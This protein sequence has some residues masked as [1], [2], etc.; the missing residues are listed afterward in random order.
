MESPQEQFQST[1]TS[2]PPTLQATIQ[3]ETTVG[4]GRRIGF[5]VGYIFTFVVAYA[6]IANVLVIG[7]LI[8]YFILWENLP[9][10][11]FGIEKVAAFI[12]AIFLAW[13][14]GKYFHWQV[15]K[16]VV[17]PHPAHGRI[18]RVS[19]FALYS[20]FILAFVLVITPSVLGLFFR[21]IATTDDTDL[22]LPTL[23]IQ[24][25]QNALTDLTTAGE[26]LDKTYDTEKLR[27]ILSGK[28]WDAAF[29]AQAIASNTPAL[30]LYAT[31]AS[32]SVFQDPVPAKPDTLS[33]ASILPT[34]SPWRTLDRF[35]GVS[36]LYLAHQGKS[37]EA[38]QTVLVGV[39]VGHK[40]ETSQGHLIEWLVGY[41]IKIQALET[42]QRIIASSSITTKDLKSVA[43][44]LRTYTD[45]RS[46][47]IKAMKVEYYSMKNQIDMIAHG[48]TQD[49]GGTG[50]LIMLSSSIDRTSFY[51]HPNQSISYLA[52][53]RKDDIKNIQSGCN[54]IKQKEITKLA[55]TNLA[56]LYFTPNAIGIILHD[57]VAVSLGNNLNTK[58]CQ[59]N[60]LLN[61]T[62]LLAAIKAY[63][64]DNKG[65]LPTSLD[66]LVPTYLSDMPL[67]PFTGQA[68]K[69]D[70]AKQII[71][72]IGQNK[73]DVGGSVGDSWNQMENPTFSVAF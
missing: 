63:K 71:Y 36:A 66:E 51:F 45:D 7:T 52:D 48:D 20:M 46:G 1:P 16:R 28:T 34:L 3:T 64:Q 23:S 35:N 22:Q 24:D 10:G 53:E 49:A 59:E 43:E 44:S 60:T 11:A 26:A 67:D 50:N 27:A 30:S 62:R 42:I 21:D 61:A 32:K 70:P 73:K 29:A 5:L 33:P 8:V 14:T 17:K 2:L 68:F 15:F 57:I 39:N 4:L 37:A 12:V 9:S 56:L 31:A 40:I 65:K 47:L 19:F 25:N 6:V 55:P 69:Y 54:V 38:L 72:S 58:V 41:A 13:I 18:L